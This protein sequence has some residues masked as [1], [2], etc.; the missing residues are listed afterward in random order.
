MACKSGFTRRNSRMVRE[1]LWIAGSSLRTTVASANTAVLITALNAAALALR[2][3]TV[4]RIRGR[5]GVRSD[6]VA[7]GELQDVAYGQCVVSEQASAIGVT[8]VPTPANDDGSDLFFVYARLMAE[9]VQSSGVGFESSGLQ[10][11]QDIDSRAMRKVEEGQDLIEVIE[12]SSI[13]DGAIVRT[14][15]RTLIKLH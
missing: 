12:A 13:S 10:D 6:Q 11:V 3:F 2:P 9:F 1:T 8:A 5:V 7:T 15:S 4:V 14:Y